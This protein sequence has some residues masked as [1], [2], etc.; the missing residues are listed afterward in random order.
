MREVLWQSTEAEKTLLSLMNFGV[1]SFLLMLN[2]IVGGL[3]GYLE[4]RIG[5]LSIEPS[6]FLRGYQIHTMGYFVKSLNICS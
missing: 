2:A 6:T 4:Y 1:K 5:N 3:R